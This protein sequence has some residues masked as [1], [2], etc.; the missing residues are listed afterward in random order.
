[1]S[2]VFTY[3]STDFNEAPET[4][5]REIETQAFSST[6]IA[7]ATYNPNTEE[8]NITFIRGNQVTYQNVPESVWRAMLSAPSVG[9][10]FGQFIQNSYV[11]Y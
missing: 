11:G 2:D 9:R 6:R 1:M 5:Q 4:E 7:E 10:Y 3:P 8:L